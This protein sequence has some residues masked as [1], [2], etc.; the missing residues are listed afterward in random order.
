MKTF[1]DADD[2]VKARAIRFVYQTYRNLA[3]HDMLGVDL[4]TKSVLFAEAIPIE[5]LALIVAMA[6]AIEADKDKNGKSIGGTRKPKIQSM[7]SK[8]RMTAAEKYMVMGYLGYT[9]VNGEAQVKAFINRLKLTDSE[10]QK[11]L[12]YSGYKV[13]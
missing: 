10:K 1:A 9:N 13:A 5:K 8:L 11:L 2:E 4:E 3:V 6:D 7:V 12:E